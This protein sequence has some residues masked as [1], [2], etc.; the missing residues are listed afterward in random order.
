[1]CGFLSLSHL[2]IPGSELHPVLL[3][4]RRV[5]VRRDVLGGVHLRGDALR[6]SQEPRGGGARAAR[7]DPAAAPQLSQL[8]V[9]GGEQ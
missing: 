7:P 9:R 1:M 5:G 3:K 2:F 8:R 6:P 4:E